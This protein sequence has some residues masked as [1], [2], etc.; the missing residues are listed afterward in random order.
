MGRKLELWTY[1][2]QPI[3]DSP[4]HHKHEGGESTPRPPNDS[5]MDVTG[6]VHESDPVC[7]NNFGFQGGSVLQNASRREEQPGLFK[8]RMEGF[9]VK[10]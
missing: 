8:F 7:G 6:S 3:R 1:I 4:R 9:D 5:P 2:T 10:V